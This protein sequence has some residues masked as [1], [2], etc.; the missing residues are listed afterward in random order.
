[1]LGNREHVESKG[2]ELAVGGFLSH[3]TVYAFVEKFAA[4]ADIAGIDVE[5]NRPLAINRPIIGMRALAN[6]D[7]KVF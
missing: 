7:F 6:K 5:I 2:T 1:M 4:A 3:T